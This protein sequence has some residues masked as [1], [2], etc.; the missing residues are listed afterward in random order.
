MG[1][2]KFKTRSSKLAG[3]Y[4]LAALLLTGCAGSVLA[5]L[6]FPA[7]IVG[8]RF[9]SNGQPILQPG[10]TDSLGFAVVGQPVRHT[11]SETQAE[12]QVVFTLLN[13]AELVNNG[14]L[15]EQPAEGSITLSFT[16]NPASTAIAGVDYL[17]FSRNTVTI[18]DGGTQA[19]LQIE[20][21]DDFVNDGDRVLILDLVIPVD[22]EPYDG[23]PCCTRAELTLIDNE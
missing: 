14:N 6:L 19:S 8:L 11:I 22:G 15:Q 13:E 4:L 21:I 16:V 18:F 20:L 2:F 1:P 3:L 9:F 10:A 7:P 23:A 12:Q 17:A 5:P